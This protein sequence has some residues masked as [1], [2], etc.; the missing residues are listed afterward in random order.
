MVGQLESKWGTVIFCGNKCC[1]CSYNKDLCEMIMPT[2]YSRKHLTA[3]Y[4]PLLWYCLFCLMQHGTGQFGTAVSATKCEMC[5]PLECHQS[6][7]VHTAVIWEACKRKSQSNTCPRYFQLCCIYCDSW[8][9]PW[10]RKCHYCIFVHQKATD[11][12]K[13]QY[14]LD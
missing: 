13:V 14:I 11:G 5:F 12:K 1:F 10:I 8:C 7:K 4:I 6:A 9:I 2:V 3:E